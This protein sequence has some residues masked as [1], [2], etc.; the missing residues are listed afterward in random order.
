MR[1]RIRTLLSRIGELLFRRS[2]EARLSS[3]IDH[4]LELLVEEMMASGVSADEARLA[5]RRQFGNVDA[6]RIAHRDQRGFVWLDAFAQDVRFGVRLLTR[7]R[8]F[9]L[10]AI[11]VLGV[12]IGVNNM[13]F[14]LVYAHKFRGLPIAQ[15]DR[16]LS[17]SIIDDRGQDHPLTAAEFDALAADQ[18]S[19][20]ALGAYMPAVVTVGDPSRAADRYDAAYVSSN[21]FPAL[22]IAPVIGRVPA[23]NQ[24]VSG[25]APVVMLG[26]TIWR[27]RYERDPNILGRSVLINGT[28]VTV[29]GIMPDRSGFPT[30][31]SV[32]MPIGQAPGPLDRNAPAS[33]VLGRLNASI[34]D[35]DAAAQVEAILARFHATAGQH[36]KTR[37]RVMPI[38]Q[39]LLGDL[40]GWGAFIMAGLVVILVAC[41][42]VAN[43]MIARATHRAREVAVRT[44]LGA[45]RGRIV[46]QLL[47]EASVIAAFGGVLGI[48]FS[49]G[50]VRLFRSA[51]PDGTLPYWF[52]YSMD[53]RVFAALVAVSLI[54][55]IVFGLVPALHAS[56]TNVN[57][58]LKDDGRGHI[59]QGTMRI[60]TAAFLTAELALA[61]VMLTQVAVGTFTSSRPLDTD[62]IVHATD[63][64]T[65]AITLPADTYPTAD[66]RARFFQR[67]EQ[68]LRADPGVAA[69]TRATLLP[70]EGGPTLTRMAI[71]GGAEEEAPQYLK[72]G[73]APSYFE[74]LRVPVIKGHELTDRDAI[75][76]SEGAI[77]NERFVSM[78][79]GGGD[80]IGRRVAIPAPNATPQWLTIVGVA[81]VIRQQGGGGIDQQTP[82][83]YTPI[84]RAAPATAAFIVRHTVDAS[85]VSTTMR[86]AAHA[87][88]PG[89]ALY[90]M[91]SLAAAIDDA[92]WNRRVSTYLATT[93]CLLSVLLA[94][95][96][97]Y[98]VTAQRV[99]L[100]TR[101]IGVRMALGAQGT[102]VARVV[103]LGLRWP[104]LL[105]L[106]L[107]LLGAS[108]WDRAFASGVS[109]IPAVATRVSVTIV[110]LIVVVCVACAAPLLKVLRTNPVTALRHD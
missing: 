54:T 83:I 74:T 46:R 47:I 44:S 71:D 5:A 92:Q 57:R 33:R 78:L 7:E 94:I 3:E 8:G 93:V 31:A 76:G 87:L 109:E 21:M 13:F 72:I 88:D 50:G 29:A 108:G 59:S 67:L 99:A 23:T 82:V 14:T 103:L 55:V 56:R 107:G 66:G 17:I 2:R 65:A 32:W 90:R 53:A 104:V 89:V 100:R 86:A 4:H 34:R 69:V 64:T 36:E 12:G 38:N 97:L 58:A 70:G 45:T 49:I 84:D 62:A 37:V 91:R 30:T 18:S 73:I 40:T 27:M 43:L 77:V 110:S 63:I 9:A 68:R 42:N 96:G 22:G 26:D 106:I 61:M 16:V 95:V 10:A 6:A 11:V 75:A 52:D 101:E 20:A 51:I 102:Q 19:F 81:R 24:D 85:S 35:S 39:R 15:P 60:W 28:P 1:N 79:L 105:G 98:A 80:P 41:A 48:V 25:A